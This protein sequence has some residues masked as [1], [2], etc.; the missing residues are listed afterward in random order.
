MRWLSR[1]RSLPPS[2]KTWVLSLEPNWLHRVVYWSLH[3]C[4]RNV[5]YVYYDYIRYELMNY[6]VTNSGF[7][8]QGD[9]Q[10]ALHVRL[11]L[12]FCWIEWLD[13]QR[14]S[15]L[16]YINRW[17]RKGLLFS[18]FHFFWGFHTW[19]CIIWFLHH[20]LP[21]SSSCASCLSHSSSNSWP[22]P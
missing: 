12:Y 10:K 16:F 3:M 6:T 20:P 9:Y 2:L 8:C 1:W 17:I 13:R 21:S 18:Y 4:Q 22:P 11:T 19:V 5:H 14:Q 15:R 7:T